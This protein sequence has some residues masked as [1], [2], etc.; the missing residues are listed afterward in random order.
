MSMNGLPGCV[1]ES[2]P[3]RPFRL[4]GALASRATRE[5]FGDVLSSCLFGEAARAI[6]DSFSGNAIGRLYAPNIVDEWTADV[7]NPAAL[8]RGEH[9]AEMYWNVST[10]NPYQVVLVKT[11]LTRGADGRARASNE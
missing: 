2:D 5:G 11:Q 3:F 8:A 6:Q 7:T 1:K 10:W 9:S 4:I